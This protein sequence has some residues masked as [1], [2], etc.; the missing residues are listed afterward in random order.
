[1]IAALEEVAA[2]IVDHIEVTEREGGLYDE[3]TDVAPPAE[4]EH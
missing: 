3:I 4:Q 2:E 1:M